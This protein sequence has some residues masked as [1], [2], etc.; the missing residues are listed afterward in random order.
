MRYLKRGNTHYQVTLEELENC[1]KLSF[2]WGIATTYIL[3]N[4]LGYEVFDVCGISKGY[5]FNLNEA[6][7][8]CLELIKKVDKAEYEMRQFYVQKCIES[9]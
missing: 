5:V 7:D 4:N 3:G 6:V 9:E 1:M 8:K 2:T